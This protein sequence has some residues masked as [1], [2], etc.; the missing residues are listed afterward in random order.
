LRE[1]LPAGI[2]IPATAQDVGGNQGELANAMGIHGNRSADMKLLQ[3]GLRF[4]S[5][6]GT[7]G[8]AGRGFYVNAASAQE[9][10]LETSGTSAES[11]TGG[12]MLNVIPKEGGNRFRGYFFSNY[13][14]GS[15]QNDNLSQEH[16]DRGLLVVNSIDRIWD[17]NAAVG[18][19]IMQDKLWFYT[20][21]ALR[22]LHQ[23]ATTRE[24]THRVLF[25]RRTRRGRRSGDT[26]QPP[27]PDRQTVRRTSSISHELQDNCNT[28][29]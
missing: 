6:E 27:A 4:N 13:T 2:V 29:A 28:P 8:G 22:E 5:M 21:P 25:H 1:W 3:D 26:P 24:C 11:E 9:V 17:V 14:N 19:P 15:M 7:A 16:I 23:D 12:I 10:S 18:G 20:A